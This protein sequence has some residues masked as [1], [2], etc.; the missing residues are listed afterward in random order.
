[1]DIPERTNFFLKFNDKYQDISSYGIW[2][3][4]QYDKLTKEAIEEFGIK[5]SEFPPMTLNHLKERIKHIN[6][7]YPWSMHPN[8][9]LV[10]LLESLVLGLMT[11]GYFLLRLYRI[12]SHLRSL[13][14]LK[15]VFN[16]TADSAQLSELR[17]QLK[18]HL[19]SRYTE[20]VTKIWTIHCQRYSHHT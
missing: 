3:H 7:K 16:G 10:I 2:A 9:L 1:M 6:D 11:I 8:I 12:R 13:K 17:A 14:D 18:T 5:L 15:N 4:V 20:T 19:S